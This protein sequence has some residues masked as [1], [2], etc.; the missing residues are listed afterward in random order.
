[1]H[2]NISP[3]CSGSMMS[4][5]LCGMLHVLFFLMY[6][7]MDMSM[8][9]L[10]HFYQSDSWVSCCFT[11]LE[12]VGLFSN[13]EPYAGQKYSDLKSQCKSSGQ[14]FVD[15]EFP[16]TYS[17]LFRG[18]AKKIPD[19]EW[20]RPKVTQYSLALSLCRPANNSV[21]SRMICMLYAGRIWVRN[22]GSS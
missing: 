11:L 8:H 18:G 1:M 9:N 17:S 12:M 3:C 4:F 16:A 2:S 13:P 21:I 15:P 7:Y 14:L 6:M 20:K 22:L 5:A 19:I 10:L